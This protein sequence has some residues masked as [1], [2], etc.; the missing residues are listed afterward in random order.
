[1]GEL[2]SNNYLEGRPARLRRHEP[3]EKSRITDHVL[4]AATEGGFP[5][6]GIHDS[7]VVTYDQVTRIKTLM[8]DAAVAVVGA[9]LP[10]KASAPGLD[11]M[12]VDYAADYRAF[13]DRPRTAGYVSRQEDH[14]R[15]YPGRLVA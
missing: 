11:E 7:F 2:R 5:V 1:M 4:T 10:V 15:R 3:Q 12:E 6:L 13:R 14:L 9:E 8:T